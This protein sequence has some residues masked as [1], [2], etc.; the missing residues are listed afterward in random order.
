MTFEELAEQYRPLIGRLARTKFIPGM[1]FD[2]IKQHV[3]LTLWRC[4]TAYSETAVSKKNNRT[5][6]FTHFFM[7][8]VK[9]HLWSTE[10]RARKASGFAVA[11]YTCRTGRCPER[12]TDNTVACP[13]CNQRRWDPHRTGSALNASLEVLTEERDVVFVLAET[14][15]TDPVRALLESEGLSMGIGVLSE[16]AAKV[17]MAILQ[18]YKPDKAQ[19]A[20]LL[21]EKDQLA[22]VFA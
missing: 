11:Y 14:S 18:G 4:Q 9:R 10:V 20:V 1:D 7:Q 17:A 21:A 3:L 16:E 8:S 22:A 5:S 19:L 13:N 12:T 6:S 15:E 2:D